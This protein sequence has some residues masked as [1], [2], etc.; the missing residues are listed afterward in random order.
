[1]KIVLSPLS[2]QTDPFTTLDLKDFCNR[3][4]PEL[5][6]SHMKIDGYL[7][8]GGCRRFATCDNELEGGS[9]LQ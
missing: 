2:L 3:T 4:K 1:M 9:C 8:S 6:F 5:C 7:Q